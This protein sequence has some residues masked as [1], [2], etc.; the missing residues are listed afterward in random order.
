MGLKAINPL[1][2]AVA[3]KA[4]VA[5]KMEVRTLESLGLKMEQ[6]MGDT[7]HVSNVEKTLAKATQTVEKNLSE[8]TTT[9]FETK[10]YECINNFEAKSINEIKN[11]LNELRKRGT[12]YYQKVTKYRNPENYNNSMNFTKEE[13]C[14]FGSNAYKLS[15]ILRNK[16]CNLFNKIAIR[17]K[18]L[19]SQKFPDLKTYL[20]DEEFNA[21]WHY[22]DNY[23]FNRALRLGTLS[24]NTEIRMMDSAFK[25]APELKEEAVVYRALSYCPEEETNKKYIIDFFNS[26]KEGN[27]IKD[28]AYISTALSTDGDIFREFACGAINT[29]GALMRIKLPKGTKPI[30]YA[31]ECLL[32]RN[33]QLKINKVQFIDGVKIVDAEYIL[34]K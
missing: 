2:K 3:K 20:N 27:V 33:S 26:L 13:S 22:Y 8:L 6:F 9:E 30:V 5:P 17:N 1:I 34:Q 21:L 28:K 12:D 24:E 7:I 19:W 11:I 18:E 16:R 23:Q 29:E 10:V 25:K 15:D 14:F 32:P 31:D 4:Y